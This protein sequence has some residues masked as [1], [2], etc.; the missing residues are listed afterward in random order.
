MCLE[1]P[2]HVGFRSV[3]YL[4]M[5]LLVDHHLDGVL[6]VGP[7]RFL[8]C[9][10]CYPGVREEIEQAGLLIILSPVLHVPAEQNIFSPEVSPMRQADL[11]AIM[12][13]LDGSPPLHGDLQGGPPAADR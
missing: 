3:H 1:V 10:P 7:L 4:H 13:K 12:L 8:I 9:D 2:G 11:P 6:A 5:I